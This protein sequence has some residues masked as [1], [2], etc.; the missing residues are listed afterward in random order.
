MSALQ[1]LL[2]ISLRACDAL[3]PLISGLY[4]SQANTA[5]LKSDNSVLTLADGIVQFMLLDVLFKGKFAAKIGEEY[6]SHINLEVEPYSINNIQISPDFV[7][8]INQIKSSMTDI[9]KEI[10]VTDCSRL[11]VFL[12]PIDGTREFSTNCGEQSS[13]CIGFS[14]AASGESLAGLIYRPITSPPSW[15]MGIPSENYAENNLIKNLDF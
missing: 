4:H 9:S 3:Q 11:V 14:D 10:D 6:E 8:L 1:R 5:T 13:T 15:A 2:G 12:D 7:P